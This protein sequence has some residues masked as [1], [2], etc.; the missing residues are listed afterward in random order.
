MF[1]ALSGI[2]CKKNQKKTG[3][4]FQCMDKNSK[5]FKV[6]FIYIIRNNLGQEVV[7]VCVCWWGGGH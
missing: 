7:L 2:R 6:D 1:Q 3:R 5:I 4:S